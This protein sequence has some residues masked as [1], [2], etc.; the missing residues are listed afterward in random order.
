MDFQEPIASFARSWGMVETLFEEYAKSVN[1]SYMSLKVLE[2][3]YMHQEG[4][5]QKQIAEECFFTKQ[6]INLIIKGFWQQ[7]YV[8]LQEQAHDR[9]IKTVLLT[10]SG[11]QYAAQIIGPLQQDVYNALMSI[12]EPKRIAFLEGF[13]DYANYIKNLGVTQ[14]TIKRRNEL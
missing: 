2:V 4:C 11:K 9:R 8:V 3:L 1:L 12:D 5:T 7:E 14:E 6:S 13:A 10:E